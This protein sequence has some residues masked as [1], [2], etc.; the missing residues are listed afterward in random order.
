MCAPVSEDLVGVGI[1]WI[2]GEGFAGVLGA[3]APL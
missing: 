3:C 2:A 1:K